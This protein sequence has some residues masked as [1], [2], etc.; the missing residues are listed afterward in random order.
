[1]VSLMKFKVAPESGKAGVIWDEI[2][3][4]EKAVVIFTGRVMR[5]L[6]TEVDV[7]VRVA[8]LR[9]TTSSVA[10]MR[11]FPSGVQGMCEKTKCG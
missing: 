2:S 8:C 9:P 11:S 5:G 7:D 1:M 3:E 4:V 10:E 6:G